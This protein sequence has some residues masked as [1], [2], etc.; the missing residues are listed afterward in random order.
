[1]ERIDTVTHNLSVQEGN[2]YEMNTPDSNVKNLVR[3]PEMAVC[4]S[5]LDFSYSP[6]T[7]LLRMR[8][9]DIRPSRIV[10]V[11]GPSGCGKTTLLLLIAG[12][13]KVFSGKITI[14]GLDA[15][16]FR[17]TGAM[18]VVFQSPSL[19]SWRT[20][21]DN[22]ALPF[23]L[24]GVPV[25]RERVE[26]ALELVGLSNVSDSYID[27]LSGGMQTRVAIARALVTKPSIVLMD[28]P[29]GNLDEFNRL[30]LNI[31]LTKL[32][33]DLG[34]TVI[35]VT[36]NVSEAVLISDR[37]LVLRQPNANDGY[38]EILEDVEIKFENKT[39]A[40]VSTPQFQTTYQTILHHVQEGVIV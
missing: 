16:S 38:T 12:L 7:H 11:L 33:S 14:F 32:Q 27:Q 37:I 26:E 4:I 23:E 1:M 24:Q 10:S 21:A 34:M 31:A 28:E 40:S 3:N 15:A 5:E 36:H 8:H 19:L 17:A 2:T 20:V 22:V 35:F 18:S 13:I 39:L 6:K 29:F 30:R 9:L 25:I